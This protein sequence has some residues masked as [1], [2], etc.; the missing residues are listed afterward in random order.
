MLDENNYLNVTRLVFLHLSGVLSFLLNFS[1]QCRNLF[2]VFGL[3]KT[4]IGLGG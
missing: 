1:S 2:S 4:F 3:T